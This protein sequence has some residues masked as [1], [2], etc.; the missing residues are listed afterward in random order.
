MKKTEKRPYLHPT[1]EVVRFNVE[2]IITTSDIPGG[3]KDSVVDVDSSNPESE[4][5]INE[6]F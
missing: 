4:I 6:P 2:D 1:T 5:L 3:D